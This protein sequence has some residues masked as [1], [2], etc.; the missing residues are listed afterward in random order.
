MA[1]VSGVYDQ[2]GWNRLEAAEQE[3]ATLGQTYNA[4]AVKAATNEVLEC[5]AGMPEADL[6]H[7]AVHGVYDP[8]SVI[9][10]LVL[11]DGATLDPLQVKGSQLSKKPF[12]FLNA[13]QVGSA[14]RMLGDYSGLA[15]AFLYAGA[16]GV[17]AP[18]WSV[19]DTLAQT[20]ALC[21]Y[22]ESFGGRLPADFLRRE[23]AGFRAGGDAMSSTCLSYLFYGHPNFRLKRAEAPPS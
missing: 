17:V 15:E 8:N 14:N 9:N 16:S 18:L 22:E 13:C 7:F 20:I 1:V 12:V 3:A 19:K 21:F 2:P 23:R 4:R 6:M 11:V 10:G 5:L